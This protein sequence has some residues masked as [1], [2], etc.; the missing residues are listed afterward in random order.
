MQYLYPRR[1]L[2]KFG[3]SDCHSDNHLCRLRQYE[4]STRHGLFVH[5]FHGVSEAV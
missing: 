3:N 5:Y 4:G 1:S 2:G